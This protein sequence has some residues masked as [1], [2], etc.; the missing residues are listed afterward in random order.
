MSYIFLMFKTINL[1]IFYTFVD[2]EY[3]A[4]IS[5]TFQVNFFFILLLLLLLLISLDPFLPNF[6]LILLVVFLRGFSVSL[7]K[8]TTKFVLHN[9][10]RI[11][12]YLLLFRS[13]HV[14]AVSP[15]VSSLIAITTVAI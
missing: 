15:I 4:L 14:F 7:S 8:I 9:L 5:F 2:N 13:R 10:S 12:G 3:E 1:K 6:F 11:K